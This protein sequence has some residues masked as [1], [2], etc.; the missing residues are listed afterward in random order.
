MSDVASAP[1]PKV[2]WMQRKGYSSGI[3][4]RAAQIALAPHPSRGDGPT[5]Q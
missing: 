4:A 5:F 3:A 2:G 1:P